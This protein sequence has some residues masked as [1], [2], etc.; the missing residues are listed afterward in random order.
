MDPSTDSGGER[1]RNNNVNAEVS[2]GKR[3]EIAR[4]EGVTGEENHCEQPVLHRSIAPIV[5]GAESWSR[6]TSD[7][8]KSTICERETLG[9]L[10]TR[11]QAHGFRY[12]VLDSGELES[13]ISS[14]VLLGE[15]SG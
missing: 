15:P 3:K 13:G 9:L 11:L 14:D 2:G 8:M 10:N 6:G 5:G 12:W 4:G 7:R 1:K